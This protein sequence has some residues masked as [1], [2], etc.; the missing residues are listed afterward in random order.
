M[1]LPKRI[2]WRNSCQW[3]VQEGPATALLHRCA[4]GKRQGSQSGGPASHHSAYD[5]VYSQS[6]CQ[7][8]NLS[9]SGQPLL[10]EK[11]Y[12]GRSQTKAA[13]K[14]SLH[15]K[16]SWKTALIEAVIPSP[17]IFMLISV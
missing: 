1:R 17:F 3:H 9:A 12:P 5:A 15:N 11:S 8:C 14:D 2:V 16:C 6:M 13:L 7:H 4:L 10:V